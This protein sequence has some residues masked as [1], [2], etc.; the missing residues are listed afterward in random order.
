VPNAKN[1]FSNGITTVRPGMET[2][3]DSDGFE[4]LKDIHL[5]RSTHHAQFIQANKLQNAIIAITTSRSTNAAA[6][7]ERSLVPR[8][9]AISV[10]V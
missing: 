8:Q 7:T 5:K 1:H 3:S 9:I 4:A 10:P 2:T 6:K